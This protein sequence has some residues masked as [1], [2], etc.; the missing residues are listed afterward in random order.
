M[1]I[2]SVDLYGTYAEIEKY[3][4]NPVVDRSIDRSIDR[5]EDRVARLEESR[6]A[7][8]AYQEPDSRT[9]MDRKYY[10][11]Q[12]DEV[13]LAKE[14]STMPEVESKPLVAEDF[15][16]CIGMIVNYTYDSLYAE[17]IE[18][19]E[20]WVAIKISPTGNPVLV[21]PRYLDLWP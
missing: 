14:S 3:P 12:C 17:I 11:D 2:R 20:D 4:P 16:K 13:T 7:V 5:M 6:L 18:I 21:S 19:V 8:Q 1:G 9:M 15:R 10:N